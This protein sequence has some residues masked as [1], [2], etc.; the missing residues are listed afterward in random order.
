M[1]IALDGCDG[2]GKSTIAEKLANK[3]GCNIVHLTNGGDRT[4]DSYLRLMNCEN[5]VHDRTFMSEVVYPKYFNKNCS[6]SSE[7]LNALYYFIQMT[8]I[9]V[10]ILTAS[11]ETLAERLNERGD[12]YLDDIGAISSINED[13]LNIAKEYGF[14]IIDTTDKTIDE[15][16]EEI[17]GHIENVC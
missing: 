9:K 2:V 5:V 8:D 14:T 10:F 1:K 11:D 15:I 12:E 6:L 17:G 13:Y 4:M 3:F 7:E 16:I